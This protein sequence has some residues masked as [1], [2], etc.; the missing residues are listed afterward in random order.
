MSQAL[1][2]NRYSKVIFKYNDYF[3]VK[4]I[5]NKDRNYELKIKTKSKNNL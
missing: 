1:S 4:I 3:N 2:K 5:F